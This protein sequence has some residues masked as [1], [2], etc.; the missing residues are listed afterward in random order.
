M[1]VQH[2]A[3]KTDFDASRRNRVLGV[4]LSI[5]VLVDMADEQRREQEVV[6]DGSE[7]SSKLFAALFPAGPERALPNGKREWPG[8]E[9]PPGEE[10]GEE[11]RCEVDGIVAA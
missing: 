9:G 8:E 1:Q 3:V 11:A 7:M 4:I 6:L 5:L 2:K 10:V